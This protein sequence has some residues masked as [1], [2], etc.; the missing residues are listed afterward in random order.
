MWSA[1]I[2]GAVLGGALVC[3]PALC[4]SFLLQSSRGFELILGFNASCLCYRCLVVCAAVVPL[5]VEDEDSKRCVSGTFG[6]FI[7]CFTVK[8]LRAFR[9]RTRRDMS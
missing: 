3:Y 9:D 7:V 6:L 8:I 1:I 4:L 2:G 5:D